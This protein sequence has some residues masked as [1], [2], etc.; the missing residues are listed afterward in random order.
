MMLLSPSYKPGDTSEQAEFI[1]LLCS[2]GNENTGLSDVR[3]AMPTI[4]VSSPKSH[5]FSDRAA[6][7]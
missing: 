6:C 1:Q 2:R 3:Q 5:E 7:H 4:A